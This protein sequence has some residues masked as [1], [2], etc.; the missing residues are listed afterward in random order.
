MI[1]HPDAGARR[2]RQARESIEAPGWLA[3][4]AVEAVLTDGRLRIAEEVLARSGFRFLPFWDAVFPPLLAALA[5]PPVALFIKG[6]VAVLPAAAVVGARRA[7]PY[8]REVAEHLGRELAAGGACVVSGMARGVDAAAHRGALAAG[9]PTVAVW[10]AGCDRVYPGEHAALADEI[11]GH[12]AIVTEYPPGSPPFAHHFP[13]RNRIIAGLARVTVVV[14][15][16]ERSGALVT[17]RLA[18][19]EGREVMAVPGS[20]FSRL[21]VG[22][23]G[24]LRAGAAPVLAAADV[25]AVLGL[26]APPVTGGGE[27]PILA[28]LPAGEAAS[29]DHVS[30]VA[31][32]PISR[33]LEELLTLEL[34]GWV[35]REPDGR[36]R[37]VR[38]RRPTGGS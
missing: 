11:A 2:R 32:Q 7:S 20:I 3:E 9:G 4:P 19:D 36:Y 29:A 12:G 37:R 16:D 35:A 15:A 31:G 23:N 17:A 5:D 21:S 33:V 34:S 38:S 22:P 26:D 13:E 10:G 6:E 24:L 27:P 25:L 30:A 1:A 28:C 18:L 14:E 8:G